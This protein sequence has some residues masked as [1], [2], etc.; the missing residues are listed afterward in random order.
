MI[1]HNQELGQKPFSE[2]KVVYDNN[3]G[4]QLARTMI[5]GC[6]AWNEKSI[7]KRAD[8]IIDYLLENPPYQGEERANGRPNPIYDQFM[9]ASYKVAN[10]VE[11]I[12]PARFLFNV[13]LTSSVTTMITALSCQTLKRN[14]MTL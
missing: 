10:A 9:E 2:K 5:T 3:A 12:T 8:W 1:R 11:L 7:M 14:V 13:G 4:L 6:D